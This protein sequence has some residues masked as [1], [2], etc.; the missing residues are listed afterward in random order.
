MRLARWRV[1][2]LPSFFSRIVSIADQYDSMT[3]ARV[4]AR[5][6]YTPDKALSLIM[7]RSGIQLDPL[8][9]KI[10]A[11]IIGVHPIGTLVML[12]TREMGLVF[13]SNPNPEKLDRPK[14]ILVTDEN[15]RKASGRTVDLA[16]TDD[17]GR[18]KRNIVKSLDPKKYNINLA[19]YYL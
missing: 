11:N 9:F 3:S 2:R 15:G 5:V 13:E 10:F 8:L 7:E 16:E 14:V 1:K 4:Y 19:E 17:A 18:H 6:P 12:D